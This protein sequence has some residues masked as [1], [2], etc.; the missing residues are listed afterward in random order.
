MDL[1]KF[2]SLVEEMRR[3]QV[4]CRQ[5]RSPPVASEAVRAERVVDAAIREI[6]GNQEKQGELW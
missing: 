2:V 3:L 1:P 4:L 5:T 6:R